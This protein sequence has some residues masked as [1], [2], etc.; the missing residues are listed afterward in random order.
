MAE[1]APDDV[2]TAGTTQ[3]VPGAEPATEGPT[4]GMPGGGAGRRDEIGGETGVHPFGTTE[5]DE[6]MPIVTAAEWGQGARG[7]AG[8]HDAGTSEGSTAATADELT[9]G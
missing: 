1:P 9:E 5:G 2:R 6:D 3:V 4:S 8:Y 7:A